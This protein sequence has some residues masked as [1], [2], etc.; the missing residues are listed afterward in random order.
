MRG[1]DTDGHL[2]PIAPAEWES[3]CSYAAFGLPR[4]SELGTTSSS[5]SLLATI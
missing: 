2:Q 3:W 4:M 1:W 5:T